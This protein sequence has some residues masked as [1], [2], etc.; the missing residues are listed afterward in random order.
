[1]GLP[2]AFTV[3]SICSIQISDCSKLILFGQCYGSGSNQKV[4][5]LTRTENSSLSW[6]RYYPFRS[7]VWIITSSP[8]INITKSSFAMLPNMKMGLRIS[9]RESGTFLS[10][11]SILSLIFFLPIFSGVTERFQKISLEII[12]IKKGLREQEPPLTQAALMIEKVQVTCVYH[13]E[14]SIVIIFQYELMALEYHSHAEESAGNDCL[15]S[16]S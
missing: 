6:I 14:K 8:Q 4:S 3:I 12:E 9:R 5:T 2:S 11:N 7:K 10:K 13:V 15:I 16:R 1:M